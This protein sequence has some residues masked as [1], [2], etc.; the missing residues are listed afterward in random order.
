SIYKEYFDDLNNRS[1]AV[2]TSLE[3]PSIP[4]RQLKTTVATAFHLIENGALE[5][6]RPPA[7]A[8]A[9]GA[10]QRQAGA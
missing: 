4:C 9:G 1:A 5:F 10:R 8:S 3:P 2:C 6:A 7:H